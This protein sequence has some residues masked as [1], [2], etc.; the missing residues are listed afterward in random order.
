MFGHN[1]RVELLFMSYAWLDI[2]SLILKNKPVCFFSFFFRAA[3]VTAESS[4]Q[5]TEYYFIADGYMA[6]VDRK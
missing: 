6:T 3:L 4:K 1:G 2:F 5:H